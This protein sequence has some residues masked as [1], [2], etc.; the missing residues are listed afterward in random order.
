MPRESGLQAVKEYVLEGAQ[1]DHNVEEVFTEEQVIK[2]HR[3]SR[4][5]GRGGAV[6]PGRQESPAVGAPRG[7]GVCPEAVPLSHGQTRAWGI[8]CQRR[9]IPC[10]TKRRSPA[11]SPPL[12]YPALP[13]PALQYGKQLV[14]VT[15]S[16]KAYL[17]LEVRGCAMERGGQERRDGRGQ[18]RAAADAPP[19]CPAPAPAD[20]SASPPACRTRGGCGSSVS[21]RAATCHAT[22]T[23]T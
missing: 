9:R 10:S 16:E 12:R 17:K 11:P 14:G 20:P 5:S 23:R 18:R 22:T 1:D 19:P 8:L 6:E 21:L 4:C 3:V 7:T 15:D 13:C 2:A